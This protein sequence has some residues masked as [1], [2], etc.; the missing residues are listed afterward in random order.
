MAWLG[1]CPACQ[2]GQHKGHVEHWDIAPPGVL[3]GAYCGCPGTCTPPDLRWL[4]RA[5]AE[6]TSGAETDTP[7]LGNRI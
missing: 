5:G 6:T 7:G 2:M 4:T 1:P 3:G